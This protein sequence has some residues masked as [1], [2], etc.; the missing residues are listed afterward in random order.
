MATATTVADTATT[1]V[2]TAVAGLWLELVG[3]GRG[4][5]VGSDWDSKA[6]GD[7]IAVVETKRVVGDEE[8]GVLVT[9]EGMRGVRVVAEGEGEAEGDMIGGA[10]AV[11][12]RVVMETF[13]NAPELLILEEVT[14]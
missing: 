2:L 11:V 3:G 14:E 8:T 12:V 10:A 6:D 13:V 7:T 5:K 4:R 1:N 9:A